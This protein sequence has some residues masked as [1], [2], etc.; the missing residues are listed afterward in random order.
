M[1]SQALAAP[2]AHSVSD[3][4]PDA[5]PCNRAA[6]L[7]P[8]WMP[9]TSLALE[10]P[11][12]LLPE[13]WCRILENPTRYA[14]DITGRLGVFDLKAGKQA[15]PQIKGGR[16]QFFLYDLSGERRWFP[17][18]RLICRAVFGPA[19]TRIHQAA[20]LDDDRTYDH[21]SNL[22]W[23][24]PTQNAG[25]V[26]QQNRK[27]MTGSK[28]PRYKLCSHALGELLTLVWMYNKPKARVAQAFNV[29]AKYVGD[30]ARGEAR[31][32]E[33]R[34]IAGYMLYDVD[35]QVFLPSATTAI[36]PMG[37]DLRSTYEDG[38]Y[39]QFKGKRKKHHT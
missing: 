6:T 4:P 36:G 13:T 38:Y 24:T 31:A 21:W 14:V 20:H 8:G 5:A 16:T 30:L 3:G 33:V 35:K 25:R 26:A 29:S 28:N 17:Q 37:T 7:P 2:M 23:Q 12:S 34:E 27:R 39:G 19:P 9:D 1:S 18:A 11:T 22:A 10:I 32:D 15:T